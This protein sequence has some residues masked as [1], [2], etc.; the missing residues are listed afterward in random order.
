M[1]VS[2][3]NLRLAQLLSHAQLAEL[4]VHLYARVLQLEAHNTGWPSSADGIDARIR[5][6]LHV[7]H[8]MTIP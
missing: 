6:E 2:E 5:S 1:K 3:E 7:L 8:K 4:V